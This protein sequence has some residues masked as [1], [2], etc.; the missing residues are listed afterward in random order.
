MNSQNVQT[1]I[2]AYPNSSYDAALSA[3]PNKQLLVHSIAAYNSSG[4]AANMAVGHS[5]SDGNWQLYSGITTPVDVTSEVQAGDAVELVSTVNGE[6]FVVRADYKFSFLSFFVSQSAAGSPVYTYEY[7][8]GSAWAAL[9]MLVNSTFGAGIGQVLFLP[10]IDWAPDVSDKYSIRMV[11]TTAPSTAIEIT[12]LKVIK[13]FIYR[14]A[15]A[16]GAYI[17][18]IFDKK[19]LLLAQGE[20]MIAYFS[21][22]NAANAVETAFQINP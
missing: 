22:T 18:V 21:V 20:Q 10:P 16:D 6:G 15:I 8:N 12:G 5:M 4:S 7:W 14:K 2:V 17:Q 1:E 13:M 9:T 19:P 3:Q 11:A